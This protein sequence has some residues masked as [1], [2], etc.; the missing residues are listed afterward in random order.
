MGRE[1]TAWKG[2]VNR[3]AHELSSPSSVI[4]KRF[5]LK[6]AHVQDFRQRQGLL[7]LRIGNHYYDE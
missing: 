7:S 3:S 1:A 2:T 6:D 4:S 5:R